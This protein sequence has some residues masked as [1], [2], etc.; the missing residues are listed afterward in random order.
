MYES[1]LSEYSEDILEVLGL[2][3]KKEMRL[4]LLA[5]LAD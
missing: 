3:R 2:K 1:S 5:L 4:Y